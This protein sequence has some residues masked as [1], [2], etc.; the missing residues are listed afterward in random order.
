MCFFEIHKRAHTQGSQQ[1]WESIA[2]V[3]RYNNLSAVS[4]NQLDQKLS[5]APAGS[6][7]TYTLPQVLHLLPLWRDGSACFVCKSTSLCFVFGFVV[8]FRVLYKELVSIMLIE[9]LALREEMHIA[10]CHS[11]QTFRQKSSFVEK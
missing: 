6:S 3:C 1:F 2:A 5:V 8:R 4:Q 11:Y 10:R 9:S 7:P